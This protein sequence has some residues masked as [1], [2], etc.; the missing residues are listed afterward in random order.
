M[1]LFPDIDIV[2]HLAN[3][4]QNLICLIFVSHKYNQ[5]K[6]IFSWQKY[7]DILRLSFHRN[8][9]P[10]GDII[11]NHMAK[12]VSINFLRQGGNFSLSGKQV[13]FSSTDVS[14]YNQLLK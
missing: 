1:F 2:G 7:Y 5:T 4:L 11:F 9:M 12:L 14:H 8:R 10:I 6:M 13:G 3:V